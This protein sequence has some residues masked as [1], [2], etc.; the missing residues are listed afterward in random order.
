MGKIIAG[1]IVV[2]AV[3]GFMLMRN[4]DDAVVTKSD[5]KTDVAMNA[6]DVKEFSMTSYYDD[7][8]KWFSLKEISVKKGDRVKIKVTN[9]KGTHDFNIDEYGIKKV[10]PLNQEVVIEFTAD[11]TGEFEYYCSMSGHRQAGQFGKL[12]VKE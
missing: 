12:I 8:G 9:T 5:S 7:A 11:K 10:T 6:G 4:N 2:V 1:I 3:I